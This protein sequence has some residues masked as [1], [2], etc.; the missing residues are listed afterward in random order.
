MHNVSAVVAWAV[1]IL[2]SNQ[3]AQLN[4]R[5][6]GRLA[7]KLPIVDQK[8]RFRERHAAPLVAKDLQRD[9]DIYYDLVLAGSFIPRILFNEL[10]M[11]MAPTVIHR[12]NVTRGTTGAEGITLAHVLERKKPPAPM[13]VPGLGQQAAHHARHNSIV[14]YPT[15]AP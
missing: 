6:T 8:A 4:W 15:S 14:H 2:S 10:T 9:V 7:A 5:T 12:A 3:R 13:Y 11:H 1:Q